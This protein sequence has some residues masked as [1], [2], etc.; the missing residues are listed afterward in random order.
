MGL[1]FLDNSCRK[2]RRR[3]GTPRPDPERR[4]RKRTHARAN[5]RSSVRTD[6]PRTHASARVSVLATHA[7]LLGGAS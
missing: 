2:E 6:I 3:T 4:A 7:R 5:V 1:A